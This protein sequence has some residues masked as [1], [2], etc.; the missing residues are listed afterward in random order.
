VL[1]SNAQLEIESL[2][3]RLRP[4]GSETDQVVTLQSQLASLSQQ[5]VDKRNAND[6]GQKQSQ[7]K[8]LELEKKAT[9]ALLEVSRLA[10][11]VQ[12]LHGT[13]IDIPRVSVAVASGAGGSGGSGGGGCPDHHSIGNRVASALGSASVASALGRATGA[14]SDAFLPCSASSAVAPGEF[15][16][17]RNPFLVGP[18]TRWT[19][20]PRRPSG[21]DPPGGGDPGD[22]GDDDE[23]HDDEDYP[24]E[25]DA[26]SRDGRSPRRGRPTN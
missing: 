16:F 11:E 3:S 18:S 6:R 5:L 12:R 20:S 21:G 24:E 23:D 8:N 9:D 4:V 25:D 1:N 19:E 10:H 15:S 17:S 22:D 2:Q 7:A 13:A 26:P 14:P